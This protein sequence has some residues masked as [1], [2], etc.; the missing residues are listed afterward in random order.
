M[1]E[2]EAGSS[3]ETSLITNQGLNASEPLRTALAVILT[4]EA[5]DECPVEEGS[6]IN[7]DLWILRHLVCDHISEWNRVFFAMWQRSEIRT[8]MKV[9]CLNDKRGFGSHLKCCGP[10][11]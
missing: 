3:L 4:S 6:I 5:Q 7:G 11:C 10:L 9:H 8:M 1:M 2:K